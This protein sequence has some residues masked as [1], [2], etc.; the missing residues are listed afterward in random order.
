MR[1]SNNAS[2]NLT[3]IEYLEAAVWSTVVGGEEQIQEVTAAKQE[4][5]DLGAIKGSNHGWQQI[6][7]IVNLQEVITELSLKPWKRSRHR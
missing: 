5:R 2:M 1:Q 4:L 6:G 7:T 3:F